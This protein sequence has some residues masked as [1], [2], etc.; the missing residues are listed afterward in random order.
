[1]NYIVNPMWFY[2]MQIAKGARTLSIVVAIL[3]T[4][5]IFI[6]WEVGEGDMDD[7]PNIKLF[8]ITAIISW[9]IFIFIP[10]KETLISMLIAKYATY[11]NAQWTLETV[12]SAVDYIVQAIQSIK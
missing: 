6:D 4:I 10:S 9:G 3:S 12:K 2:W 1:M 8:F 11:E 5:A 7:M